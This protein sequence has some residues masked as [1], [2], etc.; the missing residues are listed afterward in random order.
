MALYD[1][2]RA[3]TAS[4]G[5]GSMVM[6]A[7]LSGYQSFGVV[8]NG[9]TVPYCIEDGSAWEVGNGVWNLSTSTLSRTLVRSSTGSLLSLSGGASAFI[10]PHSEDLITSGSPTF[11][12]PVTISNNA[13]AAP[14]SF[15][16]SLLHLV[17][18][19]AAAAG[20]T[21][22]GF[23]G[24]ASLI[25]RRTNGTNAAKSGVTGAQTLCV[26]G[27]I[28]YDGAGYSNAAAARIFFLTAEAWSSIAHGADIRF[29]TTPNGSLG[30]I[31]R[32][33]IGQDG[34]VG[35]GTASPNRLLTLDHA[36]APGIGIRRAGTEHLE[37]GADGSAAFMQT[38]ANMPMA[39][40]NDSAEVFRYTDAGVIELGIGQI[41][42]PAAQN[43]SADANTLD[44]YEE[45]TWTPQLHFG[46]ASVGM[47]YNIQ[48]GR[49]TK[50]GRFV[51]A[52]CQ[53]ALASK[54]SS[55]GNA[56]VVGLP[57][58][59][60]SAVAATRFIQNVAAAGTIDGFL[61]ASNTGIQLF[62][63]PS[64]GNS[65]PLTNAGFA[66]NALVYLQITYTV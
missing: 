49:Y 24:A 5:T 6:G 61:A 20:L 36:T 7:P 58:A 33:R 44:D 38:K 4:T 19:D 43:P 39:F 41:K 17:A 37:I 13:A 52:S 1:R 62:V 9:A 23:G 14:P 46:G 8:A 54:G 2:V 25:G 35:I 64:D 50:I 15:Q 40:Y 60:G 30:P 66:N 42:F 47:T 28:G 65:M 32:M 63:L 27:G 51:H 57:F 11:S 21:L 59:A 16:N 12:G 29:D 10:S 56:L 45:G 26:I 55:T 34:S 18:G 22:D 3:V 31:E 48:S 53:I